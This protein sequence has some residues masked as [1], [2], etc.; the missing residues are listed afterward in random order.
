MVQSHTRPAS[1]DCAKAAPN[2]Y[3]RH[4][5]GCGMLCDQHTD[6]RLSAVELILERSP[7]RAAPP[8]C[9]SLY[10]RDSRMSNRKIPG[11]ISSPILMRDG[12]SV[13]RW[14]LSLSISALRTFCVTVE[15][16]VFYRRKTHE[17]GIEHEE[18]HNAR[19]CRSGCLR[20]R[21][22]FRSAGVEIARRQPYRGI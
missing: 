22:A 12:E 11:I 19:T 9:R 7:T 16:G 15:W 3:T 2:T 10:R 13:A 17:K 14:T 8:C 5:L 21:N 18:P 6:D 4:G 20:D 1:R